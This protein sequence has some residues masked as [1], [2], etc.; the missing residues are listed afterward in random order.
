MLWPLAKGPSLL[1]KKQT[2]AF[3]CSD[4]LDKEKD[5]VSML[6]LL[7]NQENQTIRIRRILFG[8][9]ILLTLM[10]MPKLFT[11]KHEKECFDESRNMT[12]GLVFFFL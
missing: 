3:S 5:P 7:Y 9:F 4:A 1:Q 6:H 2:H 8:Y 12:R 11:Q 10:V